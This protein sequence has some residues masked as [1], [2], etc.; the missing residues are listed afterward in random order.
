MLVAMPMS[1]EVDDN[2]KKKVGA[3]RDRALNSDI[4]EKKKEAFEVLGRRMIQMTREQIAIACPSNQEA[5]CDFIAQNISERQTNS[6]EAQ[7]ISQAS[8]APESN[9]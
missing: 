3:V 1:G 8:K 6:E 9:H 5:M 4:P 2:L 7:T